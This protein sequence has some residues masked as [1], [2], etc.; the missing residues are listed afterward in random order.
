[1]LIFFI[2]IGEKN[3]TFYKANLSCAI[4]PPQI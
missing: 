1:M 4:F 2:R 3:V